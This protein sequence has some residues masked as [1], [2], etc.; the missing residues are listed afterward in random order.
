VGPWS[1]AKVGCDDDRAQL[2]ADVRRASCARLAHDLIALADLR[3][4]VVGPPG[5]PSWTGLS[6]PQARRQQH[7]GSLAHSCRE[8]QS[9]LWLRGPDRALRARPGPRRQGGS[10]RPSAGERWQRE[11]LLAAF[12]A[13]VG[14]RK[15]DRGVGPEDAQAGHAVQV[16]LPASPAITGSARVE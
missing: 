14:E 9:K 1:E 2:V 6:R 4:R 13:Q 12:A 11:V 5:P 7:T 16:L 10:A 15:L 3:A 8:R